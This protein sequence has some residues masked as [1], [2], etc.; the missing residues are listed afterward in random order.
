MEMIMFSTQNLEVFFVAWAFLFQLILIIHFALR[1]WHFDHAMRFGW[2]VYALSIPAATLSVISL[3]NGQS[4]YLWLAGFVYL[5]WAI[6]GYTVEYVRRI[7]W[8]SP[9]RWSI[10]GPYVTLYLATVMFYWWPLALI[11]KPLWY[12][13]AVLFVVSTILNITSHQPKQQ[14]FSMEGIK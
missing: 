10:L 6:Y 5:T 7:Q 9:A 4:W 14:L 11:Y 1:K 13:Y 8:R 12:A 3:I 2:I